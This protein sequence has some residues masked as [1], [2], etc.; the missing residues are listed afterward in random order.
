METRDIALIKALSNGAGGASY[1]LPIASET[2]LGGVKPVTKTD[3][4]TQAVGVDEAGALWTAPSGGISSAEWTLLGEYTMLVSDRSLVID[5]SQFEG[6]THFRIIGNCPQCSEDCGVLYLYLG[7]A[8]NQVQSQS[9]QNVHALR[10]L[11]ECEL[12][13]GQLYGFLGATDGWAT[14][15]PASVVVGT[16]RDSGKCTSFKIYYSNAVNDTTENTIQ[17][18]GY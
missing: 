5:L 17:I 9:K 16:P 1:T 18:W 15:M 7:T 14:K 8:Y 3:A 11:G 13:D 6:I 4:M 10:F 2:T 12:F